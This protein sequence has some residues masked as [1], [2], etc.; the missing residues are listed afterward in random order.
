MSLKPFKAQ[1]YQRQP[2]PHCAPAIVQALSGRMMA[3]AVEGLAELNKRCVLGG[4]WGRGWQNYT[5]RAT[6]GLLTS[7]GLMGL[8]RKGRKSVLS[9]SFVSLAVK[10]P[11]G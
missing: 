2:P 6:A 10:S 3:R 7:E 11:D 8:E 5:K 4:A 9:L 1:S